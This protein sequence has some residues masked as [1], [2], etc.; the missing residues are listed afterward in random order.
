MYEAGWQVVNSR[1]RR[2]L[3]YFLD[4]IITGQLKRKL[5]MAD[6]CPNQRHLCKW[7][8]SNTKTSTTDGFLLVLY[9]KLISNFSFLAVCPTKFTRVGCFKDSMIEPR[10]LPQLLMTDR[11]SSSHMF[12][13]KPIHWGNWDAYFPD[14]ICRC[15]E[16]AKAKGYNVF[17]IQHYGK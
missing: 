9:F 14:L 16:K 3:S 13:G 5:S 17:G 11:D 10:P 12:S 6:Q 15:A 2:V 1:S 4:L 8:L 7:Q